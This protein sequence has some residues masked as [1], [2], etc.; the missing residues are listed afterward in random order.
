MEISSSHTNNRKEKAVWQRR[1]WEHII[2]DENDWKNHMN[3]IHYNPVKHGF[4]PSPGDWQHSTFRYWVDRG[5]YEKDW[6]SV[7]PVIFPSI[8]GAE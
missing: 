5:L 1:F 2:R 3:Y 8:S 6:G 7:E 4:V